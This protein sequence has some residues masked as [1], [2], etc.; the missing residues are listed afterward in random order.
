MTV[1][2]AGAVAVIT[3]DDGENRIQQDSLD[4]LNAVL[5]ELEGVEGPLAI[6]L[7]GTGKFFSN[8]LDLAR[9]A[10]D[11]AAISGTLGALERTVGRLLLFP[12]YSVAA[13]NG[14]TFAG[15][16]LLSCALDY[17]VM[18]EDRGF[19]CMNEADI[20]MT[21]DEKLAAILFSRL[22]R[23]TAIDAMVTARRFGGHEALRA[24]IVQELATPEYLLARAIEVAAAM[25]EK[26]RVIL[27]AHKR[28]AY[29]DVA[30]QLGY[31]VG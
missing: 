14:H 18:R 12:A 10:A 28:L 11:P 19:W 31:A 6:V 29:R 5:D 24:G 4:R 7:T 13:L 30:A 20:G 16:A 8:G 27:A 21:L 9:L 23:A 17:R 2:L 22:P 1:S 25:A 26:D 3:W 15:G